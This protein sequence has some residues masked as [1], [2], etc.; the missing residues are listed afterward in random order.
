MNQI[1]SII[2]II[3][4]SF[5]SACAQEHTG[6]HNGADN[7]SSDCIS[8]ENGT[9]T[10]DNAWVRASNDIGGTSAGYLRLCN[11]GPTPITLI[12]VTSD[13]AGIAEIHETTRSEDGV[14]S[15][16]PISDLVIASGSAAVF[17]PGGM[18]I[19]LMSL[20]SE[21]P[22]GKETELE[23]E[24]SDGNVV[25]VTATAKSLTPTDHNHH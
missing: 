18:H 23:F 20:Q 14:V 13:S 3:G 8:S 16:K 10:I 5:L 9:V 17:A 11:E 12:G 6:P 4:L 25:A 22:A 24:F 21:I 7:G 19:M 15:M 2:A 1:H